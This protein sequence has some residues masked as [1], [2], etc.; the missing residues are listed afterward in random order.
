[1]LIRKT[2]AIRP[3]ELTD[4]RWFRM[5]RELLGA[6]FD[7]IILYEDH[8]LR[9]RAE[10]EIMG[11]FRKGVESA[12]RGKEIIE[13]HGAIKAAEMALASA[14]PGE[15]VLLQADAIDETMRFLARCKFSLDELRYQYPEETREG[16][17]TPQE[18]LVALTEEGALKRYP[19]GVPKKARDALDHELKLIGELA[20]AA[21]GFDSSRGDVVSIQ[22]LSFDHP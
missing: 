1:M 16:Y 7:R 8:Y 15:L 2:D 5:R 20:Q 13:V 11:L 3:S 4:E 18:A 12:A 21:I 6:A 9:G 22:N 17:A 19:A 14:Q 10:G